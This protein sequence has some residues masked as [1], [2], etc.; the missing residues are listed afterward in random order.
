MHLPDLAEHLI[1]LRPLSV[2]T[3][4]QAMKHLLDQVGREVAGPLTSALERINALASGGRL[5]RDTL[6]ALREEIESARRAGKVGQQL[7]RFAAG[8]IPS[9]PEP[10]SLTALL[11][12]TLQ[13]RQRE[14]QARGITLRPWLENAEL[15]ADPTLLFTLLHALLDWCAEHAR[16]A[17]DLRLVLQGWPTQARLSLR[18][19]HTRAGELPRADLA[20]RLDTLSWR[21]AGQC[22]QALGLAMDRME[23]GIE[24]RATV[25]FPDTLLAGLA[26]DT[27]AEATSHTAIA[28]TTTTPNSQPL[29]GTHVLAVAARREVRQQLREALQHMGLILDFVP[30]LAEAQEFC[31]GGLPHAVVY[32]G[33]LGGQRFDAFRESLQRELPQLV[34][35]EVSEEGRQVEMA[36]PGHAVARLGRPMLA[37]ALPS[38]LVFELSRTA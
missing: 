36:R 1:D 38:V 12:D 5:E 2:D 3:G 25:V 21:L 26:D 20:L 14:L 8:R 11:R 13:Q 27:P 23:E 7:A 22:A 10:C 37:Q 6:L 18:F 33:A 30:S 16:S 28:A 19:V 24:T 35:V 32:E 17:V 34:F 15:H 9:R 4:A 29:A 31:R